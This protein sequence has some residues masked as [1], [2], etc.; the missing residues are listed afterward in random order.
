MFIVF[1][2]CYGYGRELDILEGVRREMCMCVRSVSVSVSVSVCVCVCV[3]F[4]LYTSAR[5][6]DRT[7]VRMS[8]CV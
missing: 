4:S 1:L 3:S 8:A 5:A 7:C 2:F 6:R